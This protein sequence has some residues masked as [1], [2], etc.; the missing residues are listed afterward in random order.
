MS[1]SGL[2]SFVFDAARFPDVPMKMG[3]FGEIVNGCEAD[4][5]VQRS[6]EE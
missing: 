2:E 4:S 6:L 5:I 3:V 1:D